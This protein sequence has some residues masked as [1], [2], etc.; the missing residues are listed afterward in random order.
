LIANRTEYLTFS[1]G[2]NYTAEQKRYNNRLTQGLLDE[3]ERGGYLFENFS[4][5]AVR[6]RIRCYYKSFQQAIKKKQRKMMQQDLLLLRQ[7]Q[8]TYVQCPTSR[9]DEQDSS[10]STHDEDETMM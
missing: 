5:A 6:D 8:G 7:Q 4:F 2:H 10:D 3:A 9:Y 1:S